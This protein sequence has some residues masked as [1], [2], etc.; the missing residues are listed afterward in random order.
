MPE[1]HTKDP[2]NGKVS[3]AVFDYYDK[4][5]ASI[6]ESG[7]SHQR[8]F[9]ALPPNKPSYLDVESQGEK[10]LKAA[11]MTQKDL[12]KV[13]KCTQQNISKRLKNLPEHWK[14]YLARQA[15]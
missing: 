11:G 13:M 1:L 8:Y 7:L 9:N 14:E 15:N 6:K 3:P 12:A 5:F 4:L 10:L 2:F